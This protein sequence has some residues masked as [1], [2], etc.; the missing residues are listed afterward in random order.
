MRIENSV[1]RI[2]LD[3]TWQ[4]GTTYF[5]YFRGYFIHVSHKINDNL[6]KWHET[7]S[8]EYL[9]TNH[10]HRHPHL[11]GA[12]LGKVGAICGVLTF[13]ISPQ[14]EIVILWWCNNEDDNRKTVQQ[15]KWW[16][17]FVTIR[18]KKKYIYIYIYIY[19]CIYIYIYIYMCA[20]RFIN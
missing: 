4:A 1:I 12:G 14:Y 16:R 20:Q 19:I 11:Q 17:F 5:K 9:C 18:K 13:R 15:V 3:I 2:S 6:V 8:N 10:K 7:V